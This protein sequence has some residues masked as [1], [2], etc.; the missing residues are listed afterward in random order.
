MLYWIADESSA[1]PNVGEAQNTI[2]DRLQRHIVHLGRVG[3]LTVT[4]DVVVARANAHIARG[5]NLVGFVYGP[6]H[7]HRAE[8]GRLQLYRVDVEL[9]LPVLASEGLRHRRTRHI[10]NL[11]TNIELSQVMQLRFIKSLAFQ[12]YQAYRQAGGIELQHHG[13]SVPCGSRRK[14]AMARFAISLTAA[15]GSVP[16]WK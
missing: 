9:N 14:S 7:I 3:K 1:C 15:S 16:G 6:H 2:A 8:L 5:Q 4:V 11:V 13:G 12:R 10:R